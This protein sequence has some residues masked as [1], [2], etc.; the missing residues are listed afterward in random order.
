MGCDAHGMATLTGREDFGVVMT[1]Y[2]AQVA[3]VKAVAARHKPSRHKRAQKRCHMLEFL[4]EPV[5][6][7]SFL[8]KT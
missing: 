8:S 1:L 5:I 6:L 7:L 2:K 3:G 4:A